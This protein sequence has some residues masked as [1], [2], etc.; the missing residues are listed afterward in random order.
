MNKVILM[1]RAGADPEVREGTVK[2]VSFRLA[3][4]YYKTGGEEVKE[5]GN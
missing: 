4:S 2:V 3:T 1:G 5:N